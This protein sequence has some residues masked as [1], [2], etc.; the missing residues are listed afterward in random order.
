VISIQ[1]NVAIPHEA[2]IMKYLGETI[3]LHGG[4]IDLCFP[5]HENE[6]AQTECATGKFFVRHWFHSEHLQVK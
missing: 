1:E 2:M 4:R 6:I 5:H 3:D